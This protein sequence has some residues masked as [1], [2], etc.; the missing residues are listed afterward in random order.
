[1][2]NTFGPLIG[3][4][5]GV[6]W[7]L[8]RWQDMPGTRMRE[9][10][11]LPMLQPKHLE[12]RTDFDNQ[13]NEFLDNVTF[14]S[15]PFGLAA[16]VNQP[17]MLKNLGLECDPT[18]W[19]D[20][21]REIVSYDDAAKSC[22]LEPNCRFFKYD[23]DRETLTRC[24]EAQWDIARTPPDRRVDSGESYEKVLSAPARQVDPAAFLFANARAVCSEPIGKPMPNV[25]YT[26]NAAKLC[27]NIGHCTHWSMTTVGTQNVDAV[28]KPDADRLFLQLCSGPPQF[29]SEPGTVGGVRIGPGTKEMAELP[30]DP[31]KLVP[32]RNGP[33][34]ALS[35]KLPPDGKLA[36]ALANGGGG[37]GGG[38]GGK[39][40]TPA[41]EQ[42]EMRRVQGYESGSGGGCAKWPKAC[43]DWVDYNYPKDLKTMAGG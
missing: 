29:N 27:K 10:I 9:P 42:H 41:A 30:Q 28:L 39:P 7:F 26:A 17:L 34:T 11:V 33:I 5:Q 37:G 1:M 18:K 25:F 38:A 2:G 22:E 40:A 35:F 3:P 24:Q 36:Q 4:A 20:E 13:R 16:F 8:K 31:P 6:G 23:R 12:T 43:R 15:D 14:Q 19:H 32:L 21:V